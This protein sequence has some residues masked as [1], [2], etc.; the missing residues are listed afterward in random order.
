MNTMIALMI[1]VAV[2]L[3]L[4]V[5]YNLSELSFVE[6]VCEYTTLKVLGLQERVIRGMI[7]TQN[8]IV[9]VIGVI[10]GIPLGKAFTHAMFSDMGETQDMVEVI[11]VNSYLTASAGAIVIALA[12]GL[13]MSG[14]IRH[15]NM[16]DALKSNE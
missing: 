16:V 9:G 10:A 5:L 8:L 2:M 7:L 6:K 3:G 1:G 13:M 15:M 12:A 14:R 11:T 4:V